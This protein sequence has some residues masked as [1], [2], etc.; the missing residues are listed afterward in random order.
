MED[1]DTRPGPHGDVRTFKRNI[2]PTHEQQVGG[3]RPPA[4]RTDRSPSGVRPRETAKPLAW[5]RWQSG[6]VGLSGWYGRPPQQSAPQSAR[7]WKPSAPARAKLCSKNCGA[8]AVSERLKR[9]SSCQS[10]AT[11][12]VRTPLPA[13]R[14]VASSTS[15][16]LTSIFLGW[17]PRNA[18]VPPKGRAS[19]TATVHPAARHRKAAA[20][21]AE[22][23]PRM[24]R[25]YCLCCSPMLLLPLCTLL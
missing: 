7:P 1:G 19:M 10:M 18:Q 8:C 9:I 12:W 6:R 21:A 20:A 4:P 25:S 16:A 14:A 11:L 15:A 2:P 3:V 24:T 17:H 13:I 23:V 5:P 22:P